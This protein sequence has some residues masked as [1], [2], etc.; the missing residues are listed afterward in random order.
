M[1]RE[2]LI[3]KRESLRKKEQTPVLVHGFGECLGQ[4]LVGKVV[5]KSSRNVTVL[6]NDGGESYTEKYSLE[7]GIRLSDKGDS[8][9]W[10]INLRELD[11]KPDLI[12]DRP[13]MQSSLERIKLLHKE[14]HQVDENENLLVEV[15]HDSKIDERYAK[16]YRQR[17][18]G[19]KHKCFLIPFQLMKRVIADFEV[20][21]ESLG[22]NQS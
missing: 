4:V 17:V 21:F 5:Q 13:S 15:W 22:I 20:D 2:R 12:E 8:T 19:G 18:D 16:F 1:K 3:R 9:G 7:D 14:S 11:P 10:Q 6:I